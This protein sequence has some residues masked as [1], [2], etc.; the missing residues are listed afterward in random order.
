MTSVP[1]QQKIKGLLREAD[2]SILLFVV[3]IFVLRSESDD[4]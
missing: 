4:K 3:K 1:M 2:F